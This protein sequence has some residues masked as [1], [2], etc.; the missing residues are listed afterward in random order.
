[1]PVVRPRRDCAAKQ[2]KRVPRRDVGPLDCGIQKRNK[3]MPNQ[4]HTMRT[5]TLTLPELFL[6]AATR[7]MLGGGLALLVS[8]RL[9]DSQ[10][11][12]AGTILTAIGLIT[13]VPLAFEALGK[14]D[15]R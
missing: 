13:T 1:M 7:A 10:R 6:I 4:A 14:S 15:V 3:T 9:T 2:D 5:T 12:I 8:K 11:G